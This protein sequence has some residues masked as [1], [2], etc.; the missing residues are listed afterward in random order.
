M[1]VAV[2]VVEDLL[3][4]GLGRSLGDPAVHLPVHQQPV[5]DGA[6]IV[7]G[8]VA[9][10]GDV[11]ALGVHLDHRHVGAEGVRGL[12]LV[13]DHL[14]RQSRLHAGRQRF[15]AR[16]CGGQLAPG[17]AAA[18]YAGHADAAVRE[19]GDVIRARLDEVGDD[20]RRLVQ[21]LGPGPEH[22]ASAQL[23][24]AGPAR[25][26]TSR[27]P[28]C[29]ALHDAHVRVGDVQ[30]LGNDLRVGGFVAL[31]VCRGAAGHGDRSV[32][33]HLDRAPLLG[34]HRGGDL[35]VGADP[36][37]ELHPVPGA[38]A[39]RLLGAQPLISRNVQRPVEGSR[40]VAAVVPGAGGR[41]EGKLIR[42]DEVAPSQLGGV[43]LQL[44]CQ[45]VHCPL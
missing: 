30:Q 45:Q 40:E 20:A 21:H 13:E 44:C 11:A 35:Y 34:S 8:D 7:H 39:G 28:S 10:R 37:T 41:G 26:L 36:D 23:Q 19:H 2:L 27:H 33:V 42:R 29:I 9:P 38:A 31:A 14:G 15:S 24:R 12:A 5:E 22:R 16:G 17:E 25:A 43:H 6:A 4:E 3:Q 1:R 18:G 32:L